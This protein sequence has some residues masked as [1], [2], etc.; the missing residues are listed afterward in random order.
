MLKITVECEPSA[1]WRE[2]IE[3][4]SDYILSS[5]MGDLREAHLTFASVSTSGVGGQR[6]RCELKAKLV[7]GEWERVT[8]EHP[9]GMAAIEG[10]IFRFRRAVIRQRQKTFSRKR[11]ASLG[12]PK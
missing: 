9:D 5:L 7:D 8:S 4:K 12:L 6:F 2:S 1:S 3:Q 11:M 10:A